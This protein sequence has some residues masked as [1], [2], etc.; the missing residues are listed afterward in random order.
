MKNE[1]R[2]KKLMNSLMS[3]KNTIEKPTT[4]VKITVSKK[5]FDLHI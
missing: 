1:R 5:F 3:Y 2:R 4:K